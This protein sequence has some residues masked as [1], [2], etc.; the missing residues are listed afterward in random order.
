MSKFVT[1]WTKASHLVQGPLRVYKVISE[2][3]PSQNSPLH[4]QLILIVHK[5]ETHY[6][7]DV[8]YME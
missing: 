7:D 8:Y 6:A 5:I 4:R 1:R 3:V 2:G